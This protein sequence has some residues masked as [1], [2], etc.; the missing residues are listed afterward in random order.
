VSRPVA[1]ATTVHALVYD[2][3]AEGDYTLWIDDVAKARGVRVTGG[4]IAEL[5]W[6][7]S[8]V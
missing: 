1:G 2:N 6:R 4:E 8:A 3:L 7:G 5:E